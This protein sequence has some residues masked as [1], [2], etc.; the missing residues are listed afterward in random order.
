[1]SFVSQGLGGRR[2]G[3]FEGRPFDD[4]GMTDALVTHG[5]GAVLA[6]AVVVG[7]LQVDGDAGATRLQIA[8]RAQAVRVASAWTSRLMWRA[9]LR[10]DSIALCLP[11]QSHG[12]GDGVGPVSAVVPAAAAPCGAGPAGGGGEGD[13]LVS[14]S[15]KVFC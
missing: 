3:M 5:L 11:D 15:E 10:V 2:D 13:H 6:V 4:Q 7:V 1:M 9:S 12:G 14:R 8:S